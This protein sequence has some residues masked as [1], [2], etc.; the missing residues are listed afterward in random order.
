[1][2]IKLTNTIISHNCIG[3]RI[4]QKLNKEYENP[5][6]WSVI[7]P[8]DFYYLYQNFANINF[9][10]I[11]VEEN[12]GDYMVVIDDKVR[13][14]YVHYKYSK[15][16]TKPIVKDDIDIF[17]NKIGEYIKEKY[18]TRLSR[19][20]GRPIFIVTDRMFVG[21]PD[22]NFKRDE[23]IKYVGKND[24]IVMTDDK[25]ITGDNVIYVRSK[26]MDPKE[27][28]D[29]LLK[30]VKRKKN[31][32]I[33][34][35]NTQRLTEAC[36]KSINKC[37]PGCSIYVFDN[38]DLE[39]FKNVFGN[40]TVLDNTSGQILNFDDI[41]ARHPNSSE[42]R[43]SINNYGS[44]KHCMSVEKCME[45]IDDD[46]VLMDSD[47]LLKKDFSPIYDNTKIF[48]GQKEKLPRFT[49]RVMPF[50]LY[51]NTKMCKKFGIHFCDEN[52]ILGI[53]DTEEGENYDT[54][55]W[56]YEQCKNLPKKEINISQYMVH[57]RA[58]SWYKD[59]VEKQNYKQITPEKWLE[60]NRRYWY[61]PETKTSQNEKTNLI[62]A[63]QKLSPSYSPEDGPA[64]NNESKPVVITRFSKIRMEQMDSESEEKKPVK[65]G[66]IVK[67]EMLKSDKR[68][69]GATLMKSR[70]YR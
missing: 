51:I 17:Y 53:K 61:M 52:H 58:A 21:K 56:F 41:L 24:C 9:E 57:F 22:C 36:I 39:P 32:L 2:N 59:A 10:N 43:A 18:F 11:R 37:T 48:V 16:A 35:Y 3:A 67:L 42:S 20:K 7:P 38:S 34:N 12:Y 49:M 31:V 29:V 54:A 47:I 45:I 63:E 68:K 13:V 65:R 44:L 40:V 5:F 14:Y 26:T 25:T 30:E 6:M 66:P 23:L 27:M 70:G 62:P 60:R 8:S 69:L 55:C 50:L 1:M 28:S 4:Y 19:M 15:N 46:F 64:N 33:V